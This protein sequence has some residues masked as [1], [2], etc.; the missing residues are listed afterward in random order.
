MCVLYLWCK[1]LEI[2][3][4]GNRLNLFNIVLT[5]LPTSL[6]AILYSMLCL[7]TASH[8]HTLFPIL[9]VL[10]GVVCV[11]LFLWLSFASL[12]WPITFRDFPQMIVSILFFFFFLTDSPRMWR[13]I[14]C[15]CPHLPS[16]TY[17]SVAFRRSAL[18]TLYWVLRILY[19]WMCDEWL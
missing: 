2:G 19:N 12:C 15:L 16:I 11:D 8:F 18:S 17:R 4:L 13:Q 6:C 7:P 1:D 10:V 14:C 5:Y 9:T 3:W